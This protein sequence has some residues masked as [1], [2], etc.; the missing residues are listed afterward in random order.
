LQ[1]HGTTLGNGW[2]ELAGDLIRSLRR[3]LAGGTGA[4]PANVAVSGQIG[5]VVNGD[6]G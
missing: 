2:Q 3:R 4:R 5:R 6:A 1:N